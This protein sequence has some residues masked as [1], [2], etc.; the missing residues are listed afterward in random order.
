MRLELEGGIIGVTDFHGHDQG[1]PTRTLTEAILKLIVELGTEASHRGFSQEYEDGV[2]H[3]WGT[4]WSMKKKQEAEGWIKLENIRA[5]LYSAVEE[6][7]EKRRE[8][9]KA[10]YQLAIDTLAR[11]KIL[12]GGADPFKMDLE[13]LGKQ[14]G[15]ED[16]SDE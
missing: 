7:Q 13:Y 8:R 5:E 11:T 14:G 10:K 3:L 6:V 15:P 2:D 1:S 9:V 4:I 12:Y 16:A